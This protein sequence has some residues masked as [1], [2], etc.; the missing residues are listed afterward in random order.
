[1]GF[2]FDDPGINSDSETLTYSYKQKIEEMKENK[3]GKNHFKNFQ[4]VS[5]NK[6]GY[7]CMSMLAHFAQLHEEV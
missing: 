3:W 7:K 5:C 6:G 4:V 1:M 2:P